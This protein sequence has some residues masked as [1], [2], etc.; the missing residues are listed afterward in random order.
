[1]W[2]PTAERQRRLAATVERVSIYPQDQS[3]VDFCGMEVANGHPRPDLTTP[4]EPAFWIDI[5]R[6]AV[7][8][9]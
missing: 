1:M 5:M 7:G 8:R 4:G 3:W 2:G 6:V 9:T